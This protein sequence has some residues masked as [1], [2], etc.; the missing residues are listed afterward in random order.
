MCPSMFACLHFHISPF[1]VIF[2]VI[3]CVWLLWLHLSFMAPWFLAGASRAP[4]KSNQSNSCMKSVDF[5]GYLNCSRSW[6]YIEGHEDLFQSH[7]V[8]EKTFWISTKRTMD[9]KNV[10][11]R[12]TY[13]PEQGCQIFL[14]T[15]Y[16][17][18]GKYTKL[19]LNH[20]MVIISNIFFK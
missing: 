13:P 5:Y 8:D 18:V 12:F 2:Q 9:E 1:Q 11:E 4:K 16:Q 20:Q 17:N 3:L 15:M 19:N 6:V 14:D 10:E 7:F